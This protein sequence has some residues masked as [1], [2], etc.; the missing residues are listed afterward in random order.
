MRTIK[1]PNKVET[2]R[3]RPFWAPVSMNGIFLLVKIFT[4]PLLTYSSGNSLA[5]YIAVFPLLSF[6]LGFA[7]ELYSLCI[8]IKLFLWSFQ[9]N[10][11]RAICNGV[12]PLM[13]LES[14]LAPR[15]MRKLMIRWELQKQAQCRGLESSLSKMLMSLKMSLKLDLKRINANGESPWAAMCKTLRFCLFARVGSAPEFMRMSMS[16]RLPW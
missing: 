8:D 5:I 3:W 15:E 4:S 16:F 2:R 12:E 1:P 6:I 11:L 14:T 9:L 7:P 13:S 10:F